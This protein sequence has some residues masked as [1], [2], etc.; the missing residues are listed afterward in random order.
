MTSTTTSSKIKPIVKKQ[1]HSSSDMWESFLSKHKCPQGQTPTHTRITG[2]S[3]YFEEDNGEFLEKYYSEIFEKGRRNES[4]TEKQCDGGPILIDLDL[5]FD[6]SVR[7]RLYTREHIEAFLRSLLKELNQIYDDLEVPV[8]VFV[9]EKAKCVYDE[10]KKFTKDGIHFLIGIPAT[11]REQKHLRDNLLRLLPECFYNLP[12]INSWE[13]VLDDSIGR[14]STNWQM[15]GSCKPGNEPYLVT[16]VYHL[17][18]EKEVVLHTNDFKIANCNDM[19]KLL[20]RNKEWQERSFTIGYCRLLQQRKEMGGG[21][22]GSRGG[23]SAASKKSA[24][25]TLQ[26]MYEMREKMVPSLDEIL[27]VRSREEWGELVAQWRQNT[28]QDLC[29]LHDF[30]MA[31]P[32]HYYELGQGTREKWISTCWA[33]RNTDYSLLVAWIDFSARAKDFLFSHASLYSLIEE[34]ERDYGVNHGLTKR[35]IMYWCKQDNPTEYAEIKKRD[36]DHFIEQCALHPTHED[37]A[38]ILHHMYRNDFVY[39]KGNVWYQNIG[40]RW[41]ISDNGYGLRKKIQELRSIY[42][43]KQIKIHEMNPM[44][45]EEREGGEPESTTKKDVRLSELNALQKKYMEM[46][47]KLGDTNMKDNIMKE[48][49]ELFFD[50]DFVGK[51]DERSGLLCFNNG[52][53]DFD[54]GVFRRGQPDDFISMCTNTEFLPMREEICVNGV[55]TET[56]TFYDEESHGTIVRDIHKFMEEIYPNAELREYMWQHLASSLTGTENQTFHTYIGKGSNGKSVLTKLMADIMGDYKR[57]VPLTLIT[58]KRQK[59]GGLAPEI[60]ELKGVRYAVMQESSKGDVVNEGVLKQLTSGTDTIQGRQLF[61]PMPTRF[62]PQFKLVMCTNELLDIKSMDGGTWRRMRVVNH[63]S[64]F[65]DNPDANPEKNEF[66]KLSETDIKK[67][68]TPLWKQLFMS[69]LVEKAFVTKGIVKDCPIVMAASD[70]YKARQDVIGTFVTEELIEDAVGSLK[71]SELWNHY[72]QWWEKT[73]NGKV[74][75]K[76]E[77]R[78][79]LDN[80]YGKYDKGKGWQGVR[81]LY[82]DNEEV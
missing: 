12:V 64:R 1:I 34:W 79:F 4:M 15:Y 44:T 52:I 61:T 7:T 22:T 40:H 50:G 59:I 36:V 77:L 74:S 80:K 24:A 14:G 65:V 9:M 43:E 27:T 76:D 16:G 82:E 66:K 57:D 42:L 32:P 51:L 73:Q 11:L 19:Q 46:Y 48:A 31:L 5:R 37:L 10:A 78:T 20:A 71:L 55:V 75:K 38:R 67:R 8:E 45:E 72:K 68:M 47:K 23:N 81:I 53:V 17:S 21:A 60:A 63:M 18:N 29:I 35:S 3:Y 69:L 62:V 56:T 49:R 33:L 25:P 54:N 26:K 58:E 6:G 39:T 70:A 13:H 28:A 2:G 30:V 41:M